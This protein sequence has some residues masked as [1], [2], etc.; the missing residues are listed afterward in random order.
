M[1]FMVLIFLALFTGLMYLTK[2][3]VFSKQPH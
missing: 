3:A 1:G 2:K